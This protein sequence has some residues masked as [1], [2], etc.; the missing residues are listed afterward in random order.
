MRRLLLAMLVLA[1]PTLLLPMAHS[2]EKQA[3]PLLTW[4]GHSFFTI[5]STKGTI[6]AFDPHMIQQYGRIEGLKADI[7]LISHN[8][9][10]HTQIGVFEN[11]NA[12][13]IKDKS[14]RVF[15][16]LKGP[17][18]KADWND[19]DE[20][21]V[22]KDISIR[23]VGTFH[24]GLEGVRY[25]KNSIFIVE[26][27]GWKFC[28]MGD[29]GHILSPA[30]VKK[31]GP[32]DVLMVPVG[33]IYALNGSEA[34]EVVAQLKPKEYIFPMHYGTKVFDDLLPIKEF[35]E[36]Q[37]RAKVTSSDDNQILLNRDPNRPRPLIVELNYWPKGRKE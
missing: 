29:L 3:M 31:I 18:L 16:G 22:D 2:G 4:H 11:V 20:K 34:R 36:E 6:I 27:D 17:G 13:S 12:K 9:N 35:L 19:I 15:A 37:P 30:Q 25:G 26:V 1:S 14:V 24:D 21:I 10:D 33:G 23:T 5:K 28:H 8:H 7:I 32:I